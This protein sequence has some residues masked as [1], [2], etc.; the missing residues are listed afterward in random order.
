MRVSFFPKTHA[1]VSNILR[2]SRKVHYQ[3]HNSPS[4]YTILD[5]LTPLHF[6]TP[7]LFHIRSDTISASG[8]NNRSGGGGA[9]PRL[10]NPP[11]PNNY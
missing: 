6:L 9:S 2:F 4:F 5:N 7:H 11:P 10:D 1:R 3:A 8:V